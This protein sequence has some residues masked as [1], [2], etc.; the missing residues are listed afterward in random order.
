MNPAQQ[1]ERAAP[2]AK[3]AERRT[4]AQMI[5]HLERSRSELV[6]AAGVLQKPL[7]AVARA[8]DVVRNVSRALPYAVAALAVVGV[9]SSLL[10]GR[11]V[12]PALLIA[13]GLDVWRLW[14]SYQA[15]AALQRPAPR[16]AIAARASTPS[17][18]TTKGATK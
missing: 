4:E 12:R 16:A 9:A 15:T 18:T 2:P 11:K 8:E 3:P 6:A 14:R 10:S 1:P 7:N 13:T 5:E 17:A